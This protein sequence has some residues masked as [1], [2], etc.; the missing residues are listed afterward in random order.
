MDGESIAMVMIKLKN[1]GEAS[2]RVC[3]TGGPIKHIS[4][5]GD[6][7]STENGFAQ[8]FI[9]LLVEFTSSLLTP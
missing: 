9:I 3:G 8:R 6:D 7:S 1:E 5:R 2:D 4:S